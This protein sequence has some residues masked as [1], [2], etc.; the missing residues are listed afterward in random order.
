MILLFLRAYG[1]TD[2]DVIDMADLSGSREPE[3]VAMLFLFIL[4]SG[5]R[6]SVLEASGSHYAAL[7]QDGWGYGRLNCE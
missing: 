7:G 4:Q 5:T 6:S 1:H 2:R 3:G